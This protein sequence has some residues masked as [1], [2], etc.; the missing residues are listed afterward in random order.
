MRVHV[1]YTT[2]RPSICA[3]MF[4][5]K[6]PEGTAGDKVSLYAATYMALSITEPD[7][8]D[9]D[10]VLEADT[11]WSIPSAS[12]AVAAFEVALRWIECQQTDTIKVLQ[13]S[14]LQNYAKQLKL[15]GRTQKNVKDFFSSSN[16]KWT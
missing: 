6:W 4:G 16:A 5:W 9:T 13:T 7:D 14:S 10:V 2:Y 1:L 12:E 8:D 15:A 3:Y 11:V